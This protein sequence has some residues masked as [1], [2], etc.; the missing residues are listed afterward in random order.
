MVQGNGSAVQFEHAVR[1]AENMHQVL[2]RTP[3]EVVVFGPT[4]KLLTTFSDEAP[5]IAQAQAQGITIMSCGRSMTTDVV[6]RKDLLPG[7]RVVPFGAVY[8]LQREQ[9]GW[10]YFRP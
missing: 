1:L 5:L 7:V 4:V 9:A 3:F 2:P 10:A 8:I 6:K